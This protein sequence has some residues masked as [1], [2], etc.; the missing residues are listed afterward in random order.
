[1]F[2][3]INSGFCVG[4][5]VDGQGQKQQHHLGGCCNNVDKRYSDLKHRGSRRVS[6]IL[7][8]SYFENIKK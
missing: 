4:I 6:K 1:M 2:I 8:E 5:D 3:K 7:S